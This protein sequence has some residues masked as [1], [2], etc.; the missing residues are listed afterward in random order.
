MCDPTWE[1][2]KH[3]DSAIQEEKARDILAL[4]ERT[5]KFWQW[6]Q[7]QYVETI[8]QG[9]D[10]AVAREELDDWCQAHN[11]PFRVRTRIGQPC[12]YLMELQRLRPARSIDDFKAYVAAVG[13][14]NLDRA[15]FIRYR[16]LQTGDS[17]YGRRGY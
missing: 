2:D 15:E 4:Q 17:N 1:Y 12:A 7:R 3:E 10:H 6:H 14:E 16:R 5:N 8:A 9:Y 13:V 11:I